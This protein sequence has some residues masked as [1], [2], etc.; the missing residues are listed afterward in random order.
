MAVV[1]G[2]VRAAGAFVLNGTH[3][4]IILSPNERLVLTASF[5]LFGALV[6]TIAGATSA[7]VEAIHQE[8][9][10]SERKQP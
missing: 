1:V 5:L 9:K 7:I 3:L 4:D 2:F 10:T 6:G 8:K